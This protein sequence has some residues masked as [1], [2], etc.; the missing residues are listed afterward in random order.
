M[1]CYGNSI[2]FPFILLFCEEKFSKLHGS[3]DLRMT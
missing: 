3:F 2:G 1:Y